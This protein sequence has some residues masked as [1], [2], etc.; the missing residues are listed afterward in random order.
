VTGEEDGII[1]TVRETQNIKIFANKYGLNLNDLMTLNYITD[2]TEML[3]K[4]QEVFINLTE[5]KAN[6]IP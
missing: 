4:G 1:Y 6:T 2:D 3:Q 5:E